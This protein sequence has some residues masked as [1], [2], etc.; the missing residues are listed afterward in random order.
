VWQ[1]DALAAG[2][3]EGS[4]PNEAPVRPGEADSDTPV[5][6][7]EAAE[8]LDPEARHATCTRRAAAIGS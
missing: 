5:G 2:A 8:Q 1:Q 3:V 6:E 7:V 4:L